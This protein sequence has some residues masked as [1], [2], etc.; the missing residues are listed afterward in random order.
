MC[1]HAHYL[2]DMENINKILTPTYHS[3]LQHG[4]IKDGDQHHMC[5]KFADL[6]DFKSTSVMSQLYHSLR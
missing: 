4:E 3:N 6:V 1:Y 5:T 2:L